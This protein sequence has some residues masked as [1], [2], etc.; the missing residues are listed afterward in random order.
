MDFLVDMQIKSNV[1]LVSE[2]RMIQEFYLLFIRQQKEL[3]ANLLLFKLSFNQK[4]SIQRCSQVIGCQK[5]YFNEQS[6]DVYYSTHCKLRLL[7]F[8]FCGYLMKS[9]HYKNE[10]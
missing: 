7:Q 5:T 6:C 9:V 8:E 10:P 3:A 1:R 2:Q 4:A